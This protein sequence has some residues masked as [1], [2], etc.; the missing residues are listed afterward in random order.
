M[1]FIQGVQTNRIPF[2]KKICPPKNAPIPPMAR[3]DTGLISF[4]FLILLIYA[5]N[6]G[7]QQ[8]LFITQKQL[9]KFGSATS[10]FK[11]RESTAAALVCEYLFT[12]VQA[13]D[14]Q[15][16]L[17]SCWEKNIFQIRFQSSFILIIMAQ[18]GK[19]YF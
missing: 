11:F 9:G 18:H 3:M 17:K 8:V 7:Q 5:I 15:S 14:D 13:K 12:L 4:W 16:I 6:I 2:I 1:T 10:T 19:V